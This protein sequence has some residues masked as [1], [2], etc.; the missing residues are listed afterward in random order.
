MT[1]V[2]KSPVLWQ[3]KAHHIVIDPQDLPYPKRQVR[4][5]GSSLHQ[6]ENLPLIRNGRSSDL[7][8]RDVEF[9]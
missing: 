7:P 6:S 3:L 4:P 8:I 2:V 1:G 5:S 9:A